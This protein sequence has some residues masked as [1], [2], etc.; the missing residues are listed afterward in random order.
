MRSL[1]TVA[2]ALKLVALITIAIQNPAMARAVSFAW[3]NGADWPSGTTVE[4]CGNG[5]VC[6]PGLTGT[7][8]MLDL[9]IVPGDVI[10]AKARAIPPAGYQ[11]G[12]P[13]AECPPSG[14]ATLSQTLPP[15]PGGFWAN[16]SQVIAM[17]T[18]SFSTTHADLSSTAYTSSITSA[19][20]A[21]SGSDKLLLA[22]SASG[23]GSPVNPNSVKWGGS[24]GAGFTQ[25]G[26]TLNIGPYGKLSLYSLLAPTDQTSTSYYGWPSAQ[27][28][29]AGGT[30]LLTGVN[31]S[32][33]LGT[34]ATASGD[35]SVQPSVS[36][37][38]EPGDLVVAA[39]WFVDPNGNNRTLASN[40]GTTVYDVDV[41][42][43]E[44]LVIQTKV[45]TSTSTTMNFTIGG[46]ADASVAWGVI[47]VSVKGAGGISVDLAGA[48]SA[49][50]TASGA[51]SMAIPVQAAAT[52]VQTAT[53]AMSMAIPVQAA[54]SA[55]S[56]ATG[57][58]FMTLAVAGNAVTQA[59]AS[60]S[61]AQSTPVSGA[62][63]AQ[64]TASGTIPA[65]GNALEGAAQGASAATGQI[66]MSVL[67]AGDAIASALAQAGITLQTALAAAAAAQATGAGST[68]QATPL[69]G[70]ASARAA[71]SGAVAQAIPI[72]GGGSASAT[73]S[74]D[75]QALGAG[76]LTGAA[77][78]IVGATGN[79]GM[80]L[81]VTGFAQSVSAA[82]GA[83]GMAIPVEGSATATVVAGGNLQVTLG[84]VLSGD[85]LAQAAANGQIVMTVPLSAVALARAVATGVLSGGVE[86]FVPAVWRTFAARAS[87]RSAE[88]AAANRLW[89]APRFTRVWG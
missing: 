28:E 55:L 11:C 5:N 68:T 85:A 20:W 30:I 39:C 31:Q 9:P 8:A 22:Y 78:V 69:Q 47:G 25:Q 79:I 64:A 23:A 32:A 61:M 45:A 49:V 44:F 21:V 83:L 38:S 66:T 6:Q 72:A 58:V 13:L 84:V 53:G 10:Q 27:D 17:A 81:P 62:A 56:A 4:L 26:S 3:D 88:F 57:Q 76:A 59:V 51:A 1:T 89:V 29:L 73:A 77:S 80:A 82:T 24:S 16:K 37:A 71:G 19:S 52:T 65:S 40:G 33:P 14:W 43:F 35:N 2:A 87:D 74:G 63:A 36:V 46:S 86:D 34:V 75:L 50:V 41:G 12:T 54:A 70:A 60:G 48:A 42:I 67:L 15:L 18:P 7:T